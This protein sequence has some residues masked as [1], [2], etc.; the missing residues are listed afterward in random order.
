MLQALVN[1]LLLVASTLASYFGLG[2]VLLWIA[3]E[4]G[5][6]LKVPHY[7]P[8]P[9]MVAHQLALPS[10]KASPH[11]ALLGDS[12]AAGTGD[13][14]ASVSSM[15]EP[16][17]SGS[18]IEAQTGRLVISYGKPGAS[19]PDAMVE[20]V[21]EI[22]NTA[23]CFF[24]DAPPKP[25]QL[26]VY[27]YEGNDLTD[28]IKNLNSL[29]MS[30]GGDA[31]SRKENEWIA[32]L[33]DAKQASGS[34]KGCVSYIND[35]VY[36]LLK[37]LLRS[38]GF[39]NNDG[40]IYNKG[41]MPAR[42]L[43]GTF[44]FPVPNQGPVVTLKD[45]EKRIS[46]EIFRQSVARLQLSYP[47]T[48]IAVVY[49]PSPAAI[50]EVEGQEIE[51]VSRGIPPVSY[52]VAKIWPRSSAICKEIELALGA[53]GLKLFD[54]TPGLRAK[55]REGLVHGPLDPVHLNKVGQVTLGQSVAGYLA[56]QAPQGCQ[57]VTN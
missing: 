16:Y 39:S 32:A 11:I 34:A 38:L 54:A 18:I 50:Y 44:P 22:N 28:N 53:L 17:Y 9:A 56:S 10:D 7:F 41:T 1:L 43:A 57:T 20:V 8:R 55:A 37:N 26:I 24:Y 48:P 31:K 6:S 46:V 21:A 2:L 19:N 40:S 30:S 13:W 47:G 3:P 14:M 36:N 35:T 42:G 27:F 15:H 4:L 29:V 23:G 25:D 52:P 51:L 33:L 5:M 45:D 12:Y 49:I